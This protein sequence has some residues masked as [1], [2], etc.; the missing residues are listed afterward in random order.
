VIMLTIKILIFLE[1]LS[2]VMNYDNFTLKGNATS[3]KCKFC[4]EKT[5][6]QK[7]T[8]TTSNFV[9]HLQKHQSER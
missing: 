1:L 4:S 9:K 5:I 7:T 8:G 2:L 6:I 3:A